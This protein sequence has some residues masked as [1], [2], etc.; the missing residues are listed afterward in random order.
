[1]LS[2][3]STKVLGVVINKSPWPDYGDIRHYMSEVR[4][5]K[6]RILMTLPPE[7]SSDSPSNGSMGHLE[8]NTVTVTIR[9]QN[10]AKED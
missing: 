9:N 3:T 6:E 2:R 4:Q 10:Q 7:I 1:M 8:D 5:P